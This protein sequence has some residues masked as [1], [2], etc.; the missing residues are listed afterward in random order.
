MNY[1]HLLNGS[2]SS[3]PSSLCISPSAANAVFTTVLVFGIVTNFLNILVFSQAAMRKVA[4]D[5]YLLAK[6]ASDMVFL[7]LGVFTP[8]INCDTCRSRYSW[9]TQV[10]AL[11]AFYYVICIVQLSSMMLEALA[12]FDRYVAI[13]QNLR[14]YHRIDYKVIMALIFVYCSGFYVYKFFV[15][16]IARTFDSSGVLLYII[17]YS[18]YGL[19]YG[20]AIFDSIHSIV[21][22]GVCV[23]LI[24]VLN[25]LMMVSMKRAMNRKKSMHGG[26]QE[27][28]AKVNRAENRTTIM[29]MTTGAVVV[30]VHAIELIYFLPI[31]QIYFITNSNC[32]EVGK[33]FLYISSFG[34]NFFFYF[35]FNNAFRQTFFGIWAQLAETFGLKVKTQKSMRSVPVVKFT[36]QTV[37]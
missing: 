11:V 20:N 4:M 32:F 5:R 9:A 7:A 3:D 2:N 36:G 19:E 37:V 33:G 6:S 26:K 14:F 25:I 10:F 21:R 23:L 16:E 1:S 34:I 22:D 18:N 12:C 24:V 35:F 8:L 27:R 15:L 13:S 17:T 30:F 31:P 29:V 28:C